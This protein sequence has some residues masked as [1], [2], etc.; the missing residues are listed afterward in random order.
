MSKKVA[1]KQ[2]SENLAWLDFEM[3]G[4]DP[5]ENVIIQAAL[6]ITNKDLDPLEEYVCD[7][8]QPKAALDKMTPFVRDMHTLTGLLGRL[9]ESRVDVVAAERDLLE[10]VAGW[11]T[12]PAIL[13]GNSIGYDRRFIDRYMPALGGYLHYRM[14]DVT[15]L[16]LVAQ[17]WRREAEYSKPKDGAHDALF[18]IRES[19]SEMKHYRSKL[20]RSG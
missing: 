5:E 17:T 14:L 1:R 9:E 3:T 19:I 18:D 15:S 16:K 10:R 8:W 2:S 12:Y 7:V 11:C 4:L 13:A 20:I 6:I